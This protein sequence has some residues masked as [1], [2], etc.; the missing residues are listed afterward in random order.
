MREE[1]YDYY[2]QELRF[3]RR[4]GKAFA[5]SY[6]KVASRLQLD[7]TRCEDPHVERLLEGV[8]LLA[9]RV[10]LKLDDDF[11]EVSEALLE[12]VAPQYLRP[13]PSLSIAQFH[14]DPEQG[15]LT[16]GYVVPRGSLLF[17]RGN[18]G[19]RCT[20]RTCYETT[21]W[22]LTVTATQWTTPDAL[23]PGARA[24][25]AVAALRLALRCTGDVTF[26]GLGLSTL[27]LHLHGD[28]G[29]PATLYELLCNSC[30][31]VLVREVGTSARTIELPAS[32]LQ[33][34]GFAD[35]ERLFPLPP[36]TLSAY[37]LL[38]EYFAFPEKYLFL[39]LAAFDA[40][41]EA[42]FG[43]AIEVIFLISSYERAERRQALATGIGLGTLRLGCTPIVNLFPQTSEPI[44]LT[45]R[46]ESYPLVPDVRRRQTTDVFSVDQVVAVTPGDGG[47]LHVE[48]LYALKHRTDREAGQTFWYARRRPADWHPDGGTEVVLSFVDHAG[49]LA[50][51]DRDTAT[52]RLT[53]HNG[54]LPSRLP[55]GDERGDFELQRGGPLLGVVAL[56]KPTDVVLPPL[57]KPMLWRLVSQL[58]LNYLS[59]TDDDGAA[60]RELLYLHAPS[61]AQAAQRQIAGLVGVR[62]A[63][64][65]ARVPSEYGL[66]FARGRRVEMELDE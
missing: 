38:H 32:V 28:G 59:L 14:A 66:A 29:L 25:D 8:A 60:L 3:L 5:D 40:I 11:P 65:Y 61:G 39:D 4:M 12:V 54:S 51:P 1:L 6:P 58:S 57:G 20:F 10:H 55:F 15:R 9:A 30:L 23:G 16:T 43:A 45:Q 34:V 27:R 24:G 33:P 63:P 17:T 22:P 35:D 49:R 37:G 52:A 36:R 31:R 2:D 44:P 26:T 46:H 56:M 7:P 13:I 48:P 64:A 21:L 41:R 42:G 53:C 47:P 62:S 19:T 50:H 18:A